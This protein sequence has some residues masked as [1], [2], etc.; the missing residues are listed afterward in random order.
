MGVHPQD[1]Q[2]HQ[3]PDRS[4]AASAK[5]DPQRRDPTEER[6]ELRPVE[7]TILGDGNGEGQTQGARPPPG[8]PAAGEQEHEQ[9]GGDQQHGPQHDHRTGT[10][11][12][13]RVK[14]SGFSADRILLAGFSQGGAVA[15]HAGLRYPEALAG[16]AALSTYMPT[17]DTVE[18]EAAEANRRIPIFMAHGAMDPM[19]PPENGRRARQELTRL[20]YRVRWHEYP[21]MHEVCIEEIRELGKWMGEVL[22][23][24]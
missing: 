11:L 12:I 21:M 6:E 17:A 3:K 2:R 14:Q 7:E 16:I 4:L 20:G 18:A 5:Q 19:I 10:D 23:G 24:S 1:L 9:E 15:L 8:A 13:E 22:A